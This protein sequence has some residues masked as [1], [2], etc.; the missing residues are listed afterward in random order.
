M[1][2]SKGDGETEEYIPSSMP[3]VQPFQEGSVRELQ[4]ALND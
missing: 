2:L 1:T 4:C 3:N